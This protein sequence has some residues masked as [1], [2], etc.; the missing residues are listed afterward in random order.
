MKLLA[1]DLVAFGVLMGL[2][3]LSPWI[4]VA[5]LASGFGYAINRRLRDRPHAH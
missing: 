5:A 2:Y 3:A 4:G 1:R